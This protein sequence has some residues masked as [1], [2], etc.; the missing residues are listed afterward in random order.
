MDCAR[1]PLQRN[2]RTAELFQAFCIVFPG[3]VLR[4]QAI[5]DVDNS[6]GVHNFRKGHA[7]N[8]TVPTL[9]RALLDLQ[10]REWFW[11]RA[12]STL[13]EAN[14]EAGTITRPGKDEFVRFRPN[15]F[16]MVWF[17]FGAYDIDLMA[18]P[19][20][21][22]C[23]PAATMAAGNRLPFSTR[24]VCEGSTA[25]DFSSLDVLRVPRTTTH[26]FCF[27][28]PPTVLVNPA[29]QPLAKQREDAVV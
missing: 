8:A 13:A 20:S 22:D 3:R 4:A 23:I 7:R 19:A 15:V 11:M 16:A 18:L 17:F 14:F 5:A 21:A 26:A 10:M 6:T 24:Y 28:F 12:R 27:C 1:H 29:V 9:L 2:I 25:V